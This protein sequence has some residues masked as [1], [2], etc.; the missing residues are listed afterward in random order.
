MTK[1]PCLFCHFSGDPTE[2]KTHSA[3]CEGHPLRAAVERLTRERDEARAAIESDRTKLAD[4]VTAIDKALDSRFW[5]TEGRGSYAWD[6]DRYRQ[7]FRDAAT[8]ILGAIKSLRCLAADWSNSPMSGAEVAQARIDLR[9]ERDQLRE[10]LAEAK[11][12]M[13]ECS[14]SAYSIAS[15]CYSEERAQT[16]VK[17]I[18][19]RL[20]AFIWPTTA[21]EPTNG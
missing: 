6:D 15:G 16:A 12:V 17:N 14:T 1:W 2:L 5:L 9:A 8:E 21:K 13:A 20:N 11:A 18:N 3:T 10:Q 19:L 4:A 7:E